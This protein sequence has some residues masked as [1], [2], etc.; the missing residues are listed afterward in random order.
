[1]ATDG[2]PAP[3][4]IDRRSS[5]WNE[6]RAQRR[7]ELLNLTHE[8]VRRYGASVSMDQIAEVAQ[9]SKSIIYRYFADKTGLQNALGE[10]MLGEI[11][12]RF[13]TVV[14]KDVPVETVLTQIIHLLVEYADSEPGLY[15]FARVPELHGEFGG[16]PMINYDFLVEQYI[17]GLGKY[18]DVQRLRGF[19]AY[20]RGFSM[21][22]ATFISGTID[23]WLAA[24]E[25]IARAES[26]EDIS[27]S[28]AKYE[29]G[30][31]T[32]EQLANSLTAT[33][34]PAIGVM[35]ET[36]LSHLLKAQDCM[37]EYDQDKLPP[38]VQRA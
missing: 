25:A 27:I 21:G 11:L 38:Y 31:Q 8:A 3:K 28:E 2:K 19:R 4:K 9:T 32:A 7:E 14:M 23:S 37:S 24:R 13:D 22:V 1:M 36:S 35:L 10:R 29:L 6:H 26:G 16:A 34:I 33:I 5:R 18:D 12:A 30:L 20:T 17:V 15:I